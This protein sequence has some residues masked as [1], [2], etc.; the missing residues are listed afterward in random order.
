MTRLV[1]L[2]AFSLFCLLW[3]AL[4]PGCYSYSDQQD[5]GAISEINAPEADEGTVAPD[6]ASFIP[7]FQYQ[8]AV[9]TMPGGQ[10]VQADV[11][12]TFEKRKL[13]LGYREH[14]PETK[15]ML[16]VFESTKKHTFWMKNM[17]IPIDIIWM[18]NQQIVHI[19]ANVPAPAVGQQELPTYEPDAA[20]NFVL[21]LAAGQAAA[22]NLEVGTRLQFEFQ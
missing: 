22:F 16:F 19:E 12:D 7:P 8:Q 5:G 9:V 11:A 3:L 2:P 17:V 10:L 18:R 13:G 6:S 1:S 14:L 4:A 15:G 20:A 21:E